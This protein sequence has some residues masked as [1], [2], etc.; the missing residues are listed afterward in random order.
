MLA[1]LFKT[2]KKCVLLAD[3]TARPQAMDLIRS[4]IGHIEVHIGEKRSNPKVI[5]VGALAQILAFTSKNNTPASK[6]SDGR[7]LMVAGA[8]KHLYRTTTKWW[9]HS[10]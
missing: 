6:G 5:L 4:M 10:A 9:K 8:R 3:E 7:V 1:G 2:I